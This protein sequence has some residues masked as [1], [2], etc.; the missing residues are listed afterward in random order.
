MLDA[1]ERMEI[2]VLS[3]QG[4]SIRSIARATGRS[5]NTVR[6]YLRGGGDITARR[7]PATKRIAKLDPFK[8]C[9]RLAASSPARSGDAFRDRARPANAGG[10]GFDP[11]RQEPAI[12]LCGN[13]GLEPG[14]LYRVLRGTS[15]SRL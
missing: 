10:L 15:V 6:R 7:K 12:G 14:S 5:R 4:G 13:A 8:D 3:K 2:S 1:E 11:R 9:A